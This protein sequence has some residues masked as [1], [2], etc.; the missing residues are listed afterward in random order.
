MSIY[1]RIESKLIMQINKLW[2]RLTQR[3][4]L[5][6]AMQASISRRRQVYFHHKKWI[7]RDTLER[8]NNAAKIKFLFLASWKPHYANIGFFHQWISSKS[9][10]NH[11]PQHFEEWL[12]LRLEEAPWLDDRADA[13]AAFVPS[14]GA[15]RSHQ[16]ARGGAE[17]A[18]DPICCAQWICPQGMPNRGA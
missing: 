16:R 14:C 18:I 11:S 7:M 6:S 8:T 9:A 17:H 15:G 1:W 2:Q 13:Q 10:G 12:Q 3:I 5:W 4:T